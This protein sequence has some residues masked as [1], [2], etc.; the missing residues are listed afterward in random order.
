VRRIFSRSYLHLYLW[1]GIIFT[2]AILLF[3]VFLASQF[4]HYADNQMNL[5]HKD[6]MAQTASRTE[7]ILDKLKTYGLHMYD[8]PAVQEW[9]SGRQDPLCDMELLN[10][11]TDYM[12]TEPFIQRV[13]VISLQDKRVLDSQVGIVPL[14]DFEDSDIVA[15]VTSDHPVFLQF[16]DHRFQNQSHL[17]LILPATPT[18]KS[19]IGYLVLLLD[20]HAL[21]QQLL[22]N[23][24]NL[25]SNVFVLDEFGNVILG[26]MSSP[27]IA[28]A[29]RKLGKNPESGFL[30]MNGIRLHVNTAP[31][32]S[33]NWVVYSLTEMKAFRRQAESFQARI[34]GYSLILL[35]P[36][37]F[38]AVWN[39]R[40]AVQPFRSLAVQLQHKLNI[41]DENGQKV[42]GGGDDYAI[43]KS[44]IDLLSTRMDQLHESMRNHHNLVKAEFLRQWLLQGRMNQS[45]RKDLANEP[46]LLGYSEI[47]L[48]VCKV[49]AYLDISERYDFASRQLL[50]YAMGNIAAEV[51]E[52]RGGTLETVDLAGDHIVLLLGTNLDASSVMDTLNEVKQQIKAHQ[53]LL[54]TMAM[55]SRKF[56]HDDMRAVYDFVLELCLLKFIS[57]EDKI[58]TETDYEDY[59]E[60]LLPYAE[61]KGL[62]RLPVLIKSGKKEQVAQLL[63]EMFT[64]MKALKYSEC[65]VQ[66]TVIL[67]SVVKEFNKLSTLQNVDGIEKQLDRFTTLRDVHLWLQ[68]ELFAIID[69]LA[70]RHDLNRKDKVMEEIVNY[71]HYHFQDPNLSAEDIA[72]HVSLSA[73]YVRQLFQDMQNR[74]LSQYILDVR[75]EKV[76]EFLVQTTL[77]VEDIAVR[78]GF[79]T[80]SHFFTAFKKATGMTPNQYRQQYTKG[81]EATG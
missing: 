74:T 65:K 60:M 59:Q 11:I 77:P 18:K 26:E 21:E 3:S 68:Q 45:L 7:F 33:Q 42:L 40:R 56:I 66:L 31:I 24:E 76:K 37:L 19:E 2:V 41:A 49:D 72:R 58:Y 48:I 81:G 17:T 51:F 57:G 30:E 34:V 62:D 25:G 39:S 14:N 29:L 8:D 63:D 16:F 70:S 50:K 69:Q 13:Y 79:L 80:R 78:S 27:K 73:K 15:K 46:A 4:S 22:E 64:Q 52:G 32:V 36:L 53:G 43:L 35:I 28:D 23:N 61:L 54:V 55:S 75:L 20:N 12:S 44:G 9:L 38:A 5:Y 6:K 47:Y 71:I 10:T 67:F 1:I